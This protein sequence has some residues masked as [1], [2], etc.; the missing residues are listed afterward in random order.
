MTQSF[1]SKDKQIA[2]RNAAIAGNPEAEAMSDINDFKRAS[3]F[4]KMVTRRWKPGDVYAPHDLSD[5]EMMKWRQRSKP[6]HDAFDVLDMNP[7][8]HY[9]V[10]SSSLQI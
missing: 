10:C 5:V 3:N 8:D 7:L 4:S 6:T 2:R 1:I 9:R